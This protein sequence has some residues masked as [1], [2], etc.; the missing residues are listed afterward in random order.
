MTKCYQFFLLIYIEKQIDAIRNLKRASTFGT[1][2]KPFLSF[3]QYCFSFASKK[4]FVVQDFHPMSNV[5][6]LTPC[7][8]SLVAICNPLYLHLVSH[9]YIQSLILY[10]YSFSYFYA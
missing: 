6:P 5:K 10:F 1:N 8:G 3:V 7:I 4:G 9:F 2:S